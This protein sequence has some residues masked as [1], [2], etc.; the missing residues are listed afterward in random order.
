VTPLPGANDP[1]PGIGLP[2]TG[3]PPTVRR[4]KLLSATHLRHMGGALF[5]PVQTM[6]IEERCRI[7]NGTGELDATRSTYL[8]LAPVPSTP[9]IADRVPVTAIMSRDVVCARADIS[10]DAVRDLLVT[11]HIGCVPIVDD[12]ARPTG[13]VTKLDLVERR[14]QTGSAADVMMPIGAMLDT[15]A[16]VANAATAMAL[17]DVHHVVIVG[18]DDVLVGVVSTMDIVSWLA[19]NDGFT[20][21]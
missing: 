10:L 15:S 19:R 17:D 6:E 8:E 9:T 11:N 14:W 1:D 7:Y 5:A 12:H 21:D 13:I 20:P 16:T 4:Y 3:G 18:P 2:V